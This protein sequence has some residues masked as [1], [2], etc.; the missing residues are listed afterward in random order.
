MGYQKIIDLLD[1][2][3]TQSSRFRTKNW[4]EINYGSRGTYNTNSQIKF[5]TSIIK[6]CLCDYS[7]A[8]LLAKETITISGEGADTNARQNHEKKGVIFK[9]CAPFTDHISEINNTQTDFA[10]DP[11]VVMPMY[12]L[13]EYIDDYS[14]ISRSLWQYYRVEAH[15]TLT[16]SESFRFKIKITGNTPPDGNTKD[17]EIACH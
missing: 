8:Y 17:V 14:K 7:N 9:N 11:D 3:T 13:I 4:V 1:N 2:Q 16:F 12:N 10:K 5:K 15:N 6:S